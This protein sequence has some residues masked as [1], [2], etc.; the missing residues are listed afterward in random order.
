MTHRRLVLATLLLASCATTACSPERPA[1]KAGPDDQAAGLADNSGARR[2]PAAA[3]M[4][5]VTAPV[6]VDSRGAMRLPTDYRTA[7]QFLGSWAVAADA[8]PGATDAPGSKELHT[9]YASPGAI[10]GHR[11]NGRFPEGT[12]LVKEV[13]AATSADMTTGRVSRA[14]ELV[15]WFMMVKESRERYPGNKLWG[16]GWGWAWF[17]KGNPVQTKTVSYRDECL[18]CHV[19]AEATDWTYIDG[20]PVL[21]R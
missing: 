3:T 10:A 14:D 12:V 2:S 11:K 20:Y 4:P 15:G 17:D 16:D 8:A 18:D 21:A 6:L 13:F 7:Y 5:A 9:V 1:S 19:P